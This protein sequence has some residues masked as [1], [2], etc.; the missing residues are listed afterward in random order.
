MKS[1]FSNNTNL[2]NI[3]VSLISRISEILTI[4]A[5]RKP[6]SN[7]RDRKFSAC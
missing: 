1:K 3:I 7:R 5:R 6:N 2:G 4:D